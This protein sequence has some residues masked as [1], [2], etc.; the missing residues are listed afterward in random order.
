MKFVSFCFCVFLCLIGCA[1]RPLDSELSHYFE[2]NGKIKVLCTTAMIDDLVGEIGG[3]RVDHL[4]LVSCGL[5]PHS[6]ELVKGDD[7]KLSRADLLVGNGL[8]LEHGAS[9][10]YQLSHHKNPLLLGEEIRSKVPGQILIVDGELDPHVWMDISL[11]AE[12]VDA[13]AL[14][15]CKL[16]QE[17]AL[18]YQKRAD[19]LRQKMLLTHRE[20]QKELKEISSD[21]R[22]LVTS[23]DAFHYFTRAYLADE[24]G[25]ELRCMAPEGLAPDGQ[26]STQD[27]QRVVDH[28]CRYQ[29]GVVFPESNVSKDAL[30]KITSSCGHKVKICNEPLYGDAMGEK[31]SDA[32][33]YLGM[34]SH[35]AKVLKKQWQMQSKSTN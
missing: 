9:L 6:Y 28:L 16:D 24:Q 19:A 5:D 25:W 10:H 23:H 11:W 20:I 15:L 34:L 31:G 14:A 30:Y 32:D 13:I 3:D 8:N 22:Y 29:I 27:I 26:L 17:H 2:E 33:N 21:L 1:K 12:G 18:E 4:A 35:N 7:E